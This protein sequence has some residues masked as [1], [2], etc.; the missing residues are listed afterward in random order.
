V[1]AD[2][3]DPAAQF[4]SFPNQSRQL[5]EQLGKVAARAFLQQDGGDEEVHFE[6]RH[7]L[8][9]VLQRIFERQTEILLVERTAE[10]A[11]QRLAEFAVDHLE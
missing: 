10:F 8:G 2:G 1:G 3:L 9:Q 11:G 6:Q 5:I 4:E 7:A